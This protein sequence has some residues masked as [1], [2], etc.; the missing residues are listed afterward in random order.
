MLRF[1]SAFPSLLVLCL[2][3]TALAASGGAKTGWPLCVQIK[4]CPDQGVCFTPDSDAKFFA[5]CNLRT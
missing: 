3:A 1:T 2:P 4:V 5:A